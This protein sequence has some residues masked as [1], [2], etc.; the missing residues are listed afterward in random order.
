L[1]KIEN[2]YRNRFLGNLR[3]GIG[4]GIAFW[5]VWESV[6]VSESFFLFF[7]PI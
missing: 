1:K 7:S 6:S 5:E 3:I 4:I 2:R